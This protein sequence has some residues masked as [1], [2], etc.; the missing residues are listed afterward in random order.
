MIDGSNGGKLE[1]SL[2]FLY[3]TMT[4]SL[5]IEIPG[6]ILNA[7]YLHLVDAIMGVWW[8]GDSFVGGGHRS[9]SKLDQC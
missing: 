9:S 7:Q 1:S 3:A 2:R 5:G 6:M 8:E 4:S